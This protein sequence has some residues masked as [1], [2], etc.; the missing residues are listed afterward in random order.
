MNA[1]RNIILQKDTEQQMLYL[2]SEQFIADMIK[3]LQHD[4][5][6]EFKYFYRSSN[7]FLID[8]I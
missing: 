8:D 2:H 3:A 7:A 1:V 4:T 5:I 6:N